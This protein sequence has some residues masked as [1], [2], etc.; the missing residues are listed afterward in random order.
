MAPTPTGAAPARTE[1]KTTVGIV[2]NS[3]PTMYYG[4]CTAGD[5]QAPD[6]RDTKVAAKADVA[7]HV[8]AH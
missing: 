4:A 3:V 7:A 1:H 2:P 6:E 8:A 5:F